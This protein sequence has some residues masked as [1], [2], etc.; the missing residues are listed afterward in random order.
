M[1]VLLVADGTSALRS[2]HRSN[3]SAVGGSPAGFLVLLGEG[4][5]GGLLWADR[6]AVGFYVFFEPE[7]GALWA[8]K[9]YH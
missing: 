2:G 6:V 8:A 1:S 5:S 7:A 9:S 4:V 3:H